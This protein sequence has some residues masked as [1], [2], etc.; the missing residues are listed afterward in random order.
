M[1]K[2]FFALSEKNSTRSP[3]FKKRLDMRCVIAPSRSTAGREGDER[4]RD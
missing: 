2:D 4:H 1:A 3:F